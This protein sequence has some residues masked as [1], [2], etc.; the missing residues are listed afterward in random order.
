M[1]RLDPETDP[2]NRPPR[3]GRPEEIIPV[4]D[5]RLG[6]TASCSHLQPSISSHIHT[7]SD[8]AC[9]QL[10]IWCCREVDRG[11]DCGWHHRAVRRGAGCLMNREW[12]RCRGAYSC[13]VIVSR[14]GVGGANGSGVY[15]RL[16]RSDL[17]SGGLHIACQRLKAMWS[18]D[19]L[20]PF[21]S[22]SLP[23]F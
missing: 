14:E 6:S 8:P 13:R 4:M 12:L 11:Y 18:L 17:R 7:R 22:I 3:L 16:H 9:W 1:A 23:Q 21:L 10:H 19:R 15:L 5:G 20:P 2:T